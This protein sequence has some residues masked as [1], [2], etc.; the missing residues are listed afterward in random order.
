MIVFSGFST[1]CSGV[2]ISQK[3]DKLF[4]DENGQKEQTLPYS[5]SK[6]CRKV[7]F[8]RMVYPGMLKNI[9]P[10]NLLV[11]KMEIVNEASKRSIHF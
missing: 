3:W 6:S 1:I 5:L 2:N 4:P 8:S 9:H 11:Q 7:N 10:W